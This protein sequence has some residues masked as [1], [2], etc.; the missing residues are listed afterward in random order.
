MKYGASSDHFMIDYKKSFTVDQFLE[1][2]YGGT[3]L[4]RDNHGGR[5][6]D[7]DHHRDIIHIYAPT[8]KFLQLYL[9]NTQYHTFDEII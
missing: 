2:V 9:Y 7:H 3:M 4:G 6:D 1:M 5:G 8:D